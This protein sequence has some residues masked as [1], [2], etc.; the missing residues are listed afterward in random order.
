[1]QLHFTLEQMDRIAKCAKQGSAVLTLQ[2]GS[3]MGMEDI[4]EHIA[5]QVE[6]QERAARIRRN[7]NKPKRKYRERQPQDKKKPGNPVS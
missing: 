1:M 5:R 2:R 7:A 4:K 6:Q 3:K